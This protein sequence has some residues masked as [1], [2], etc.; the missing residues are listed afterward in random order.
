MVTVVGSVGER[1]AVS[2]DKF[3]LRH[4]ELRTSVYDT[5]TSKCVNFSVIC[6]FPNEKRWEKFNVPRTEA[7]LSVTA[8]I[9]GRTT[10]DNRLAVR[11]L[12]ITP[13]PQASSAPAPSVSSPSSAASNRVNR[14]RW[15]GR[16]DSV[17]PS[18]RIRLST[19]EAQLDSTQ[20]PDPETT[21]IPET[22]LDQQSSAERSQ[23][24]N[25]T[26]SNDHSS[27]TP[28]DDDLSSVTSIPSDLSDCGTR[29]QRKGKRSTRKN[30]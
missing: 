29:Q 7:F 3:N 20:Q 1:K 15:S 4:F 25:A 21:S 18:K 26:P 14:N 8:K 22:I 17:T 6:F 13:L 9:V 2:V 23:N 30:P 19:P 27:T 28:A 16:V 12:N 10:A 24:Q 11:V 5:S